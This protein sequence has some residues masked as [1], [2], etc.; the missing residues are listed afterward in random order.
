[1][2]AQGDLEKVADTKFSVDRG[3]YTVPFTVSITSA[4]AGA[5]IRYTTDGSP[6]SAVSGHLYTGPISIR[7]T[8]VLR[9]VATKP[10]LLPSDVD[11]QTYLFLSEILVQN[12]AS[13]IQSGFPS[14]WAGV[15]ADYAMDPRIT[16]TNAGRMLN[17]LRSLPSVLVST[18]ISNLFDLTTG[19]YANPERSGLAWERP[20]SVEWLDVHGRS[21]FQVDCGLR[22]QGGYFRA[23]SVTQKHS[24]R[25]LFKAEYGAGKLRHDIFPERNAAKEFDTLVLRAGA[26]D[27]Y[28]WNEAKDTEQ[29]TR[30]EFGRRLQL[31]MGHPAPHGVFVHLYL[32]GLYWGMYNLTERPNED[33]SAA[34]FGGLPE[35]WDSINS[36]DVKNGDLKAW[37]VFLELARQASD[38]ANY[39]K[40]QGNH[41]DGTRNPAYPIYF[42]AANYIDYMIVNMWGGNWDWP[43]KNYWYGRRRTLDS[44][45]FKFYIW[46]YENTMGNNRS[47][48]P[49][50]MISPQPRSENTGV[51]VPHYYLKNNSNYRLDFADRIQRCF[52]DNGL[53]TPTML[54]NRYRSL[55]DQVEYA[56]LAETA[57]WGDDNHSTPQDQSDWLRERD[58]IIGVY[59]PVRSD[60]VLQQLRLAG[61]YPNISAPSLSQA[62][63]SVPSDFALT[64]HHSNPSGAILYTL[65]GSDPRDRST[66]E[67]AMGAL[68]YQNPITFMRP[69][70]VKAR[71]LSDGQW[72]ALTEQ[73]FYPPQ[74]FSGLRLTEISYHAPDSGSL[75]GDEFD[76]L[77]LQNTGLS[78]LDLTGLSFT[79]GLTFAFTNYTVLPPGA[80]FLLAR[81]P[82]ALAA[83][84]PES[85]S[86]GRFSGKLDNGGETLI[87]SDSTGT[88]VFAVTY[89]DRA[90]WSALADGTGLSLQRPDPTSLSY[91]ASNWIAAAPTPGQPFGS[92]DA[93]GDGLPDDWE[94]ASG[95][96]WN[97]PDSGAD[98]DADGFTNAQE[99]LA[100]THPN[101]PA[102]ALRITRLRVE[103]GALL[104]GFEAVSNRT[105]SVFFTSSL[106][107]SWNKVME[108]SA[109]PFTRQILFTNE[110]S[111]AR[112][113]FFRVVTPRS[114][115]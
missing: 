7:R 61:L 22:I 24:F 82:E 41:P 94:K 43:F 48:S 27:G 20:A 14:Y 100:G 80:F 106:D 68:V 107:L 77:E 65:D 63:G 93:D 46:D 97:S 111:N 13:A 75:E 18:S 74:D 73:V 62:G 31:A 87:L 51:G 39:Q 26:N 104:L 32:N 71:V 25:L 101:D 21:E 10:G 98:P 92:N 30:D 58:W 40:L 3:F 72:S 99:Y 69:T 59:L 113:G 6:P 54:A 33:F 108:V 42:D 81:N 38:A 102:S 8:T 66:G 83:H 56:I 5:E 17:S 114:D 19:I 90:P 112:A 105:Y 110:M 109:L 64:I 37:N 115:R 16:G 4:T 36:G 34:Y 9:A 84:Y 86:H 89:D 67:A 76:F 47:R 79:S 60:I 1:M 55:A 50:N 91:A 44:T 2:Q 85:S 57:R 88:T 15:A 35:E 12:Q 28:S 95:T 49:T 52:F 23:R 78:A 96:S 45:G 103:D 70:V 11:T 53:L 29:F